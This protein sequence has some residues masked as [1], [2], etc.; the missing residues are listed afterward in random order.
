M[1]KCKYHNS[2]RS[3]KRYKYSNLSSDSTCDKHHCKST[4]SDIEK[5]IIEY[6]DDESIIS[7]ERITT[8]P[9]H[10]IIKKPKTN[11]IDSIFMYV[12]IWFIY[13]FIFRSN[14]CLII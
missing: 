1:G 13:N 3:I 9:P 11:I 5:G 2:K 6:L 14:T 12:I 8:L 7:N 4:C 10:N